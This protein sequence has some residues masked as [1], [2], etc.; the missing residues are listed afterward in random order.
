M[1]LSKLFI[2]G[3]AI[4]FVF[5]VT[6]IVMRRH[7][8]RKPDAPELARHP[9]EVAGWI[10]GIIA[11]ATSIVGPIVGNSD[12]GGGGSTPVTKP[13][14]VTEAP[15]TSAPSAM[16]NDVSKRSVATPDAPSASPLASVEYRIE[17]SEIPFTIRTANSGSSCSSYTAVDFDGNPDGGENPITRRVVNEEELTSSQRDAI[18]MAYLTCADAELVSKQKASV[19]LLRKGEEAGPE[20]CAA[21]ASGASLGSLSIEENAKAE[22]VGFEPDASLCAVT[23]TGRVARATITKITYNS[24]IGDS[25]PTVEFKLTTWV[26]G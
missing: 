14:S 15:P 9:L 11:C 8:V 13:T 3:L 10:A 26:R 7:R 2:P 16:P 24:G 1:D 12:G 17:H 4:G 20:Q 5:L 18:D 23:S 25:I 22:E 21:A 19:G 6:A